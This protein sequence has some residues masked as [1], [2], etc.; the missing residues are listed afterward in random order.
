M[1]LTLGKGTVF[2]ALGLLA[3]LPLFG[4]AIASAT[5]VSDAPA[6]THD[7][8]QSTLPPLLTT[9]AT[10]FISDF[11]KYDRERWF[12][13]HDWSNGDYLVN[14]WQRSQV[15]FDGKLSLVLEAGKSRKS[16]FSSGEVQ[17]RSLYGHGYF[18]T[19]MRAAKGSGLVSAFF[20]YTGPPFGKPWNEIDVE[21]AGARPNEVL[22]TFH[23]E[24]ESLTEQYQV[25]FDT[26][27]DF[28]TY[29]FDWQP[30]YI[31]WYID[32]E[33]VHRITNE[34]TAL[35]NKRQKIF[36]SLLGSQ[37][38]YEWLGE[39]D[40]TVLPVTVQYTCAA[41]SKSAAQSKPCWERVNTA[42]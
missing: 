38:L 24:G 31:E 5:Q 37:T 23:F 20:I 32:G 19:T 42:L 30:G 4:W 11:S 16:P 14:D 34:T 29:G 17:S 6:D 1:P 12:I 10:P 2:A 33:P 21:I 40:E 36:M 7:Q 25:D 8:T 15:K 27:E 26:T 41:Y 28:H 39:F 35:P 18:E 3:G 22:L 9:N 13:S